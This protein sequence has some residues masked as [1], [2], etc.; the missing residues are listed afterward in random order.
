MPESPS[1][2]LSRRFWRGHPQVKRPP[3]GL[4]ENRT[5][6]VGAYGHTPSTG[7]IFVLIRIAIGMESSLPLFMPGRRLLHIMPVLYRLFPEP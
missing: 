3:G 1:N 5:I 2:H 6:L 7:L 4:Q